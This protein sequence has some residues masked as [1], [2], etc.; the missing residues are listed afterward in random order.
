MHIEPPKI[1]KFKDTEA[2]WELVGLTYGEINEVEKVEQ[3]PVLKAIYI[4]RIAESPEYASLWYGALLRL[5]SRNYFLKTGLL[6]TQES[7]S[8]WDLLIQKQGV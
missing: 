3:V 7:S 1:I 8:Y 4:D 5:Q 2:F 6:P